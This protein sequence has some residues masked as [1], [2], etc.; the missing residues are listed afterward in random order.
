[1]DEISIYENVI[2]GNLDLSGMDLEEL[3][4]LSDVTVTGSFNCANNHLRTLK[5]APRHV[6]WNF[7]CH[8]NSLYTLNG[9]PSHVGNNFDCRNN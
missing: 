1:M 6:G 9:A 5:G 3:P 8:G 2:D 7:D 4:D